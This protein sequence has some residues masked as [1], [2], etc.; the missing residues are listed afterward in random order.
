MKR[1]G[2]K[3]IALAAA[4]AGLTVP[5]GLVAQGDPNLDQVINSTVR[6]EAES[7]GREGTGWVIQASDVQNRAGAAV[8]V[9][10]YNLIEKSSVIQVIEPSTGD[11]LDAT[12]LD[13]DTDRNLAFLEVKD[14]QAAALPLTRSAPRIGSSVYAAGFNED[15]DDSERAKAA[16]ATVKRG[17]LS[18]EYRGPISVPEARAD[19]NQL[20]LDASLI[21]GF[22]GSPLVDACGRVVGINMK[23]GGKVGRRSAMRIKDGDNEIN[24]LKADEVIAFARTAR[25]DYTD[26]DS[27]C[28]G[29]PTTTQASAAPVGD[30]SGTEAVSEESTATESTEAGGNAA[31]SWIKDNIVLVALLLLG[32]V[33]ALFGIIMLTRRDESEVEEA[34]MGGTHLGTI[35]S[36]PSPADEVEGGTA[37]IADTRTP[38]DK[39]LEIRL[40]GRGPAGEAIDIRLYKS[41]VEAKPAMLGVGGNADHRIDDNRPDHKVSRM[42]AMIGHDGNDFFVEDNKSTNSTKVSG[43]PIEP[44]TPTK[45]VHGDTLTLADVELKVSIL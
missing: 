17:V 21:G 4:V 23:S 32:L 42:H 30:G 18:R 39:E 31:L 41:A 24:A 6:I 37:L 16:T 7:T 28:N 43:Q 20:E 27:G 5:G 2:L 9:T 10:A 40:S 8:I 15:A 45:L 13:T 44:H 1:Q 25:V 35:R 26:Q 33:A 12:V 14:I 22:E 11:E 36:E 19:V 38:T 3:K 34:P 29:A